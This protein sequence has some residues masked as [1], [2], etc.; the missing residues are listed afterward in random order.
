VHRIANGSVS[1]QSYDDLAN[2]VSAGYRPKL[3]LEAFD[4]L[5]GAWVNAFPSQQL[6]LIQ[7]PGGFPAIDDSGNITDPSGSDQNFPAT[8][9][10][11]AGALLGQ[12]LILENAGLSAVWVW[13]V[14][15]S[16]ADTYATGYQMLWNVVGD[17]S[18]KMNGSQ[19]PCDPHSVMSSAVDL[20]IMAKMR[21]VEIYPVDVGDPDLSDIYARAHKALAQGQ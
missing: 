6:A 21:F 3:V 16:R 20:G 2:W 12:R 15:A 18:C 8:L 11:H 5:V 4:D 1:C 7:V 9:Y 17:A 19:A 13:D 10:E 14:V